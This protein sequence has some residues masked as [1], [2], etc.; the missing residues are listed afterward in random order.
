MKIEVSLE[1][2][3]QIEEI[4]IVGKDDVVQ[5]G[6]VGKGVTWVEESY[7]NRTWFEEPCYNCKSD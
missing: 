3:E 5:G 4:I 7:C 6:C 1:E 2:M